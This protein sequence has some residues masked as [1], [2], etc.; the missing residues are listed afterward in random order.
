[1][2]YRQCVDFLFGLQKFGIKLGLANT[3]DFLNYLGN[4]HFKYPCVHIAGT[5]GKGSVCAMLESILFS[6]GYKT[7][8]YTSPHLVRFTERIRIQQQEIEPEFVSDF[9]N[10]LKLRI[11]RK[12]YTFFEA[13]TALAFLYF[14]EQKVDYAVIETGLGGRL[15]STNLVQPEVAG[16]TSIALDH[17]EILG[18]T[19]KEIAYEKGGDNKARGS[20]CGRCRAEAGQRNLVRDLQ[21][22]RLGA[23]VS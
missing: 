6:A 7:G 8:L 5:D 10:Q 2:N 20:D 3:F 18:K 21:Q 4:P 13:T 17:T 1:M 22:E 12:Q 19:L 9:V 15:D 16:I 23:C 14:A 11:D